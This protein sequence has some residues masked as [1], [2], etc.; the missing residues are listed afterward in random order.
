M[1]E[2][3]CQYT[4]EPE[5]IKFENE[6]SNHFGFLTAPKQCCLM[7]IKCLYTFFS[8]IQ[9]RR[10][11]LLRLL[12]ATI[13]QIDCLA[14]RAQFKTFHFQIQMIKL[15]LSSSYQ[16]KNELAF[17]NYV[18]KKKTMIDIKLQF[19]PKLMSKVEAHLHIINVNKNNIYDYTIVGIREEPLAQSNI[20]LQCNAR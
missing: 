4:S 19:T 17:H 1:N 8:R 12:E 14:K 7:L 13:K 18:L 3:Q 5:T 15:G 10:Y 20:V 16:I 6:L 9:F 2:N 11:Q